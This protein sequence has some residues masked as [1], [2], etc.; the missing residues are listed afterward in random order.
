MGGQRLHAQPRIADRSQRFERPGL[1]AIHDPDHFDLAQGWFDKAA[2]RAQHQTSGVK[3]APA[4]RWPLS[5]CQAPGDCRE[6]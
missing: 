4:E 6:S 1:G 3:A 5:D 2:Y